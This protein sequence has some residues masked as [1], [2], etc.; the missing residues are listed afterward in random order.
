MDDRRTSTV[1]TLMD[2][3]TFAWR[4]LRLVDLA[5]RNVELIKSELADGAKITDYIAVT[6]FLIEKKSSKII[7]DADLTVGKPMNESLVTSRVE[8]WFCAAIEAMAKEE[9]QQMKHVD[10]Q[11]R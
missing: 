2:A 8:L 10:I 1:R 7:R 5:T 4:G 11:V 6:A 9:D 3:H